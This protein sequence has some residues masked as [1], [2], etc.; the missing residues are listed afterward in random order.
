MKLHVCLWSS[1]NLRF[2]QLDSLNPKPITE[3]LTNGLS[4]VEALPIHTTSLFSA[5]GRLCADQLRNLV[6][7]RLV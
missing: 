5:I 4:L 6:S 1:C 2:H 3:D 7:N